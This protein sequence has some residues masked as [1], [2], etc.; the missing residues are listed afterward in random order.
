LWRLPV[1]L[2]Q[3]VSSAR[4]LGRNERRDL[5]IRERVDHMA[6][7]VDEDELGARQARQEDGIGACK[8]KR[9]NGGR[10][11]ALV[12]LV[13]VSDYCRPEDDSVC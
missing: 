8:M 3:S 6:T 1:R 10:H 4:R 13:S 7:R 5:A 11:V 2:G 9:V 12:V